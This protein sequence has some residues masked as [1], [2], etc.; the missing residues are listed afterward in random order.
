M[1]LP[2]INPLLNLCKIK[3][4]PDIIEKAASAQVLHSFYNGVE[5]V[6]LLGQIPKMLKYSMMR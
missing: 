2:E 4:Q 5:S 1:K 3:D 6:I